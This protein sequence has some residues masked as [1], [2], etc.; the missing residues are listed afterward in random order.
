MDLHIMA[1]NFCCMLLILA[2]I[3][4]NCLFS[5]HTCEGNLNLYTSICHDC[6]EYEFRFSSQLSEMSKI[7]VKFIFE[8]SCLC[9]CVGHCLCKCPLIT[10]I[11]CLKSHK[12]QVTSATLLILLLHGTKSPIELFWAANCFKSNE[13]KRVDG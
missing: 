11:K 13:T 7:S 12:C 10:L 6:Y 9:L 2:S 3:S 4:Q 8:W 1:T 5:N